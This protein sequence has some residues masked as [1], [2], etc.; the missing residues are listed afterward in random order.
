MHIAVY[1]CNQTFFPFTCSPNEHV[2]CTL[3]IPGFVVPMGPWVVVGGA[4]VGGGGVPVKIE[5]IDLYE[6]TLFSSS[7][8][9]NLPFKMSK[10]FERMTR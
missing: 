4:L 8:N 10:D 7:C 1:T 5:T 6:T 2:T 9:V 3:D